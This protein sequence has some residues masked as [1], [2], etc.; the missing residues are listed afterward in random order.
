MTR[1]VVI[2]ML[3][4]SHRNHGIITSPMTKLCAYGQVE[5]AEKASGVR[6][7][8][9]Y[10]LEAADPFIV[11]LRGTS[12]S[13]TSVHG[14]GEPLSTISAGGTHHALVAPTLI[15]TRN[16]ERAGQAPRVRDLNDPAPTVTAIVLTSPAP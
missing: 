2:V 15:N 11:P 1:C 6:G 7:I 12:N 9:R 13:H 14:I 16:G 10:V 3:E 5:V 8:R 4:A